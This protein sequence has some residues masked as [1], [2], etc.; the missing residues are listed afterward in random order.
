MTLNVI[1]TYWK[2]Q[3]QEDKVIYLSKLLLVNSYF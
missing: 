2:L 1:I 3:P